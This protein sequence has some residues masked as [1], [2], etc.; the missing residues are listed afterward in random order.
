MKTE[1][2]EKLIKSGLP[3]SQVF[4]DGEDCNFSV[5]VVSSQFQN[6]SLLEK[7]KMVLATV[8]EAI[9]T[10]DLHAITVKAYSTEEWSTHTGT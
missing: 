8:N 9:S 6:C 3:D 10:G 5:T 7:Q 1:E 2:V 4:V